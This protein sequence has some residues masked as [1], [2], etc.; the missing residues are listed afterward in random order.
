[1]VK[2]TTLKV[3]KSFDNKLNQITEIAEEAIRDRLGDI[4]NYTV[5]I[6]PVDTG[7]YVTSFSYAVGAGRPRG[8]SSRNKPRNQNI[9]AM[10]QEGLSNLL[11]DIT[12]L[13]E[14]KGMTKI[15]LRNAAPHVEYV[16]KKHSVFTKVKSKVRNKFGG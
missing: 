7:A 16:E 4:A 13:G 11:S 2:Q 5:N 14:L 10:R 8:K 1:M 3:N 9:T 15:T 6:S 12:K